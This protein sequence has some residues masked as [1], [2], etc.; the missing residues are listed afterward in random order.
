VIFPEEQGDDSDLRRGEILRLRWGQVSLDVRLVRLTA[1]DIKEDS[2]K[3]VLIKQ[4]SFR[5]KMQAV[6]GTG[7]PYVFRFKCQRLLSLSPIRRNKMLLGIGPDIPILLCTSFSDQANEDKAGAAEIREF[8]FK[9]LALSSLA[10]ALR[11]MQL[12]L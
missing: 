5:D 2:S 8:A 3:V 10:N 9:P 11:K 6:S 12:S 7:V 4:M 1:A